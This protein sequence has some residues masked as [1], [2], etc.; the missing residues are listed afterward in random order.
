MT[1]GSPSVVYWD[2]SA[3]VSAL[4]EDAHSAEATRVGRSAGTHLLST[5]AWAETQAVIARIERE[6]L[7]ASVL[8]G[9][10]R[11]VLV[12]GPWRRL[13][14]DPDWS[15]AERL[16]RAWPLRGADLWHLA[17]AKELQRELPELGFL[18]FDS[19]LSAAALGEGFRALA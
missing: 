13:R 5:L 3:I 8:I 7:L 10:A 19:R 12:S 2:T 15:D 4:F 6:K 9:A 18:T 1:P 16:A 17:T 11:D 14:I